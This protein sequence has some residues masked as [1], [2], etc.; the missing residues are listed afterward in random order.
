MTNLDKFF[1]I[2]R[3]KLH[4]A[5]VNDPATYGFRDGS[6]DEHFRAW[7]DTVS[8]RMKAASVAGT[9]NHDGPAFRATCKELG[10]KSTRKS[11]LEYIKG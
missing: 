6:E 2:Y 1:D 7:A 4:E 10:I 9:F 11:I 5:I 8:A 3:V